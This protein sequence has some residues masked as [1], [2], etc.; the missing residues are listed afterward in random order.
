[1]LLDEICDLLLPSAAGAAVAD[2]RIGLGY[3]A[4]LLE[5]GKCG[6]AYTFR[7]DIPEGCSVIRSAGTL[8]G[9]RAAELADWAR[10]SDPLAASVGLATLNALAPPPPG[11]T[12]ADLLAL[13]CPAPDDEIAMVGNFAPLVEPLRKHCGALHVLE[14]HPAPGSGLLPESAAPDVLPRCQVAILSATALINRSLDGLLQLCRS[15]REIAI[16]GPST[17]MLPGVFGRRGVTLLSGVAAVAPERLLRIISEGG[18][19]RQF[20]SAV[21]KLT[22][23]LAGPPPS[24]PHA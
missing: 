9:R 11:A 20:G 19:T 18:G 16:L 2:V 5:E 21:R 12:A 6:L 1:M 22:L 15:A 14:R 10:S 23:R 24:G 13:L 7:D 17:P 4:V 3:T 8:A